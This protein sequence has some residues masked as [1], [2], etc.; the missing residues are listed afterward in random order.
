MHDEFDSIDAGTDRWSEWPTVKQ[1]TAVQNAAGRLLDA[2]APEGPPPRGAQPAA[3]AVRRVRSPR[4]CILQAASR[5]LSVSWF[6][7]TSIQATLGEL[8]VIIWNGVV[9]RPGSA[10]REAGGAQI[11][12][13][14]VLHPVELPGDGWGWR[15]EDGTVFDSAALADHCKALLEQKD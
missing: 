11:V 9:S 8:Q 13:Q 2:L 7:S 3:P 5:A 10:Q 12:S 14:V 4:G 6:P 15:G 1:R